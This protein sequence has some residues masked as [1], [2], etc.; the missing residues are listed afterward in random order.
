MVATP[1]LVV[2]A[3]SVLVQGGG[4]G[5]GGGGR[6]GAG[7]GSGWWDGWGQG[8]GDFNAGAGRRVVREQ[9]TAA[10]QIGRD[11]DTAMGYRF[12]PDEA[13]IV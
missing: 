7:L 8:G 2:A 11:G 5:T 10:G 13:V 9:S 3:H 12:S 1:P 6:N 4:P